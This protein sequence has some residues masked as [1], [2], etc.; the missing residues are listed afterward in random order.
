[1][2]DVEILILT[3]LE[4]GHQE[5]NSRQEKREKVELHNSADGGP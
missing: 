2:R 3:T 1:M 5:G 4:L